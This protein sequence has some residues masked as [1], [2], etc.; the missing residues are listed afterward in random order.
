MSD[1]VMYKR[2][3][4]L[5]SEICRQLRT[6]FVEKKGVSLGVEE[7]MVER[8][9]EQTGERFRVQSFKELTRELIS[10][11]IYKVDD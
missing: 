9:F 7:N 6:N 2:S 3:L 5:D 4:E 10:K 11:N 8:V 1:F